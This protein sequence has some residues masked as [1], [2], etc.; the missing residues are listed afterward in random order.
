MECSPLRTD[1]QFWRPFM[2]STSLYKVPLSSLQHAERR[3]AQFDTAIRRGKRIHT[4]VW[5]KHLKKLLHCLVIWKVA[6][7]P[8]PPTLAP[9]SGGPFWC[10]GDSM[11]GSR[12]I[13]APHGGVGWLGLPSRGLSPKHKELVFWLFLLSY[14]T[15]GPFSWWYFLQLTQRFFWYYFS[16][17]VMAILCCVAQNFAA[18]QGNLLLN[19]KSISRSQRWLS[20]LFTYY[21]FIYAYT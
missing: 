7:L 16:R 19:K 14:M 8:P 6:E 21:S 10:F 17:Q 2:G 15:S 1:E 13:Q 18:Q 11:C 3:W 5:K 9:H 4:S 12:Q 20:Y